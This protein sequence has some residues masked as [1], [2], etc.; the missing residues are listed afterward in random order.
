[1]DHVERGPAERAELA[2]YCSHHHNA[3]GQNVDYSYSYLY[4]YVID[5][6]ATVRSVKLSDNDSIRILAISVADESSRVKPARPLY[7]VLPSPNSHASDF[8]FSASTGSSE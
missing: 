7:D 8:S 4:G 2:W 6:P 1:L 3:A 5:L